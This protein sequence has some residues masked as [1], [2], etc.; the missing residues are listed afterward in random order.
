MRAFIAPAFKRSEQRASAGA[1]IDGLLSGVERKTGWM[2]AEEAG[3]ERPYRIQSLLGR[4]SWSADTL[5]ERVRSYAMEALGDPDGVLVVDET[6]F[7]K[8]GVHSVGVGRQYSGTAG[9]IENCQIGVFA[10][11]ASRWGHALIDRQLYLPKAW[12]NDPERRAKAHVP[13]NVAFATKPAIACEMVARLL[14]AGAPC[15]F[16]LADAVY[17][18]DHRFRRMLEDRGQPYVL[19][20][21]SNHTL[22]FLEEWALVQTDPATMISELPTEAWQP[23]SAGEGAKGQR[24]YDWAWVPLGYQT[25]EGFSRWLLA[26][27]SLRD[28]QNIAYYFAHARTGTTLAE[29]AAAAGLRWT[30][31]ECFLRTKDDLGLD[32]CEARSWHGW[33]RHMSLVMAAAAF[34]ARVTADQRRAAYGKRNETSPGRQTAAA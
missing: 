16:V 18:S 9:R 31:E 11:Y 23:L 17:G 15:A 34:L 29:L 2:L 27:R 26:R 32:H 1:F 8:K 20:V 10:S 7:L 30:I 22:R 5:C 14:D 4:S 12:A 21:R 25:A 3:L 28:P 24:L 33:H 6:G 19:A 13:E